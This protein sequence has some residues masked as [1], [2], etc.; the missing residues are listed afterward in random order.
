MCV[1]SHLTLCD[2]TDSSVHGIFQ[3]RTLEWVAISSSRVPSRLK[4][5]TRVSCIPCDADILHLC[6]TWKPTDTATYSYSVPRPDLTACVTN[7]PDPC[8]SGCL[9]PIWVLSLGS[10]SSLLWSSNFPGQMKLFL[11]RVFLTLISFTL[12]SPLLSSFA[13]PP[14]SFLFLPSSTSFSFSVVNFLFCTSTNLF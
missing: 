3:A 8:I 2:P 1:L 11:I 10:P 7:K 13:P 5:G 14:F 4:E 6:A 9:S 12:P